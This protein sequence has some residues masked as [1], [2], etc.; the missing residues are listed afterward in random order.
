MKRPR[1]DEVTRQWQDL[2][3]YE[4]QLEQNMSQSQTSSRTD[5]V[6][7]KTNKEKIKQM[8]TSANK[9][10]SSFKTHITDFYKLVK[11]SI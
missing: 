1:T 5:K 6:G 2:K 8:K 9:K 3:G 10:I 11:V 4:A 7:A